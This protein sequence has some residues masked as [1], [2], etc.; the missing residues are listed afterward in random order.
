[1]GPAV[2]SAAV[3][4]VARRSSVRAELRT[5][6][7]IAF[8]AEDTDDATEVISVSRAGRRDRWPSI[9]DHGARRRRPVHQPTV[10]F[11]QSPIAATPK[12]A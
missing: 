12:M 7:V 2:G 10:T 1:M 8:Q 9:V 5:A 11:D 3:T 4:R 6:T